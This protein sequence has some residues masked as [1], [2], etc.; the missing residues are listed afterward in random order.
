MVIRSFAIC[1]LVLLLGTSM[2]IAQ[3]QTITFANGPTVPFLNTLQGLGFSWGDVNNNGVQDLFVEP[4]NLVIANVVGTTT[5]FSVSTAGIAQNSSTVGSLFADFNGDDFPDLLVTQGSTGP[6]LYQ[7]NKNGTFTD[8]TANSGALYGVNTGASGGQIY[9]LAAADINHSGYLSIAWAGAAGQNATN[10][11]QI[12]ILQYSAN[13]FVNV[14]PSSANPIIDTSKKFECW[15]PTFVDVNNDGYP[16]LF[17]PSIRNGFPVDR[18]ILYLN[19]GKGHFYVPTSATLGYTV[20]SHTGTTAADTGI[21]VNDTVK[22]Y[23]A[24]ASAFG[25]FTNSGN[26]GLAISALA[27]DGTGFHLL[28]GNGDGTFIDVTPSNMAAAFTGTARGISFGDYDNDGNLDMMTAGNF[29]TP[30]LWHNNGDGTWTNAS[31]SITGSGSSRSGAFIDFNHDGFLD[32][33]WA[34]SGGEGLLVNSANNGN[35][36]IAFK[37]VGAGMNGSAIGARFIVYSKGGTMKQIRNIEAGGSGGATGGN[38]FAYFGLGSYPTMDSLVVWWPDGAKQTFMP[39]SGINRYYTVKEGSLVPALPVL[40]SPVNNATGLLTSVTLSWNASA[41]ALGYQVQVALDSAF[42]KI[43][44]NDSS[45]AGTATSRT[46]LGLGLSTKYYWR[47]LAYNAGFLSGYSAVNS[48]TTLVK[49]PV[50]VPALLSPADNMQN[51]P[52]LITLACS[53]TSDAAQYHW[54][55]S[56]YPGFYTFA[57]NDTTI[58]PTMTLSAAQALQSG[59]K[60]YW[61]VQGINPGGRANFTAIDSFTVKTAPV[62]PVVTYPAPNQ[63]SVRA[64]TLILKWNA[65]SNA[66]AY[67]CQISTQQFFLHPTNPTLVISSDTSTTNSFIATG[68]Q[69]NTTY[70]WRVLAYNIGGS[71]SFSTVQSFTTILPVPAAPT[72]SLPVSGQTGVPLLA[73]LVWRN[74]QYAERYHLQ[75]ATSNSFASPSIDEFVADTTTTLTTALKAG[76]LYYWHV[77]T[78]DTGG[79]GQYSAPK[80]FTTIAMPAVPVLVS[81]ATGSSGQPTTLTFSWNASTAATSYKLQISTNAFF[82]TVFISDTTYLTSKQISG[83]AVSTKYYWRVSATNAAGASAYTATWNFTTG[84]SSGD[85]LSKDNGKSLSK[86]MALLVLPKENKLGQNYPNPFNPS[87]NIDFALDKPANVSLSVYNVLGQKVATIV[88]QFMQAGYYTYQFNAS[89]LA[90]GIYFYRIEAGDFVSLKKFILMK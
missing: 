48:F 41:G 43:F 61:R 24:I 86:D 49:A 17:V 5:T 30:I 31:S 38:N 25:D 89:K 33:Y 11:G 21:I 57:V 36:W 10:D 35:N 29:A 74:V 55:I 34:E 60:Y 7:N 47:V 15:N 82:N 67:I 51:A 8:V 59:K 16:D 14:G 37:P 84:T 1:L 68:L 79:Q 71:S 40:A 81:P 52:A 75:I 63:T 72:A 66:D 77:A 6:K 54:E 64:D 70:Y 28:K 88:N 4:N 56:T 78:V 73:T 19:D 85:V 90:S 80:Y 45:I 23:S 46:V 2:S 76:T 69:N 3:T 22:Y 13:G 27:A 12:R 26:M 50:A 18:S 83:L 62:T 39:K 42:T 44:L 65:I 58:N 20:Y 53:P 87:T 32:I 9:G